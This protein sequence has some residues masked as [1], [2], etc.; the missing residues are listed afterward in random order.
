MIKDIN[1]TGD[2]NPYSF[3]L[4]SDIVFF[5]AKND[6]GNAELWKTEGTAESTVMVADI[7][8]AAGSFVSE[9]TNFDGTLF[10]KAND[11]THGTEL[12]AY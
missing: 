2:G 5:T 1:P 12:W 4:L 10:F 8:P 11:G 7:N 3:S 6:A 9:I